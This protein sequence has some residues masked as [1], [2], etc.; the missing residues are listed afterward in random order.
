MKS[1]LSKTSALTRYYFFSFI[2]FLIFW[3]LLLVTGVAFV[4]LVFFMTGYVWHFALLAPGLKEKALASK[5]KY[6][7]LSV[8]VR[9]NYYLQL[10]I[11][12]K[13]VPYSTSV[14]RAI[15]PFIFTFCLL[16]FGGSGN[17]FFTLI[18]S[19]CFEVI[20][21]FTKNV[22]GEVNPSVN[23]VDQDIPPVIPSEE[24]TH[25]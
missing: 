22:V 19:L 7:F 14:V 10:F 21:H 9:C 13:R 15:S 5:H 3:S 8:I 12:I 20:Y 4:N 2:G 25:E 24:K 6:S 1:L 16:V 11:N 18:G 17:L 23:I